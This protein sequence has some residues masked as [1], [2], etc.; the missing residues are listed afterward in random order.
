IAIAHSR[1]IRLRIAVA[2]SRA[3]QGLPG[4]ARI[5]RRQTR[6][7]SLVRTRAILRKAEVAAWLTPAIASEVCTAAVIGDADPVLAAAD[8]TARP[9]GIADAGSVLAM[10]LWAAIADHAVARIVRWNA[11]AVHGLDIGRMARRRAVAAAI[12]RVAG[13]ERTAFIGTV[14]AAVR[15]G[16]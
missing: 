1:A 9:V 5:G 2:H 7:A 8:V 6:S 4:T 12:A 3:V 13:L 11:L 14:A 10:I 16:L 15:I